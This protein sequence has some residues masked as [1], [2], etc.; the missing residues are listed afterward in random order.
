MLML[1]WYRNESI[2]FSSGERNTIDS[3]FGNDVINRGEYFR[4]W[5]R[6]EE[7][8][9]ENWLQRVKTAAVLPL[10]LIVKEVQ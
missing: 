9:K 3:C 10:L 1:V 4:S 2:N 6:V 8:R 5:R 7:R